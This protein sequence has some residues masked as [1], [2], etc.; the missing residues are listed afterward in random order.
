M[1][2]RSASMIR[3][4]DRVTGRGSTFDPLVRSQRLDSANISERLLQGH[5]V[6]TSAGWRPDAGPLDMWMWQPPS[7]KTALFGQQEEI[8]C[9]CT[10]RP[11]AVQLFMCCR[12]CTIYVTYHG[13]LRYISYLLDFENVRNVVE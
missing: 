6:S 2:P 1:I 7:A 11:N 5:L 8:M 12:F 13:H 9:N 3:E 10:G 4:F